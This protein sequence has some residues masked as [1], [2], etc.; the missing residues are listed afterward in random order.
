YG[1][2]VL[3]PAKYNNPNGYY[4]VWE[5]CCRNGIIKNIVDPDVEGM[6]FYMEFP[7]VVKNNMRFYNSS[8]QFKKITGDFP[9]KNQPFTF[10][11]SG[12]DFNNDSLVYRIATPLAGH[13]F[14]GGSAMPNPGPY[15]SIDWAPG[16]SRTNQIPGVPPFNINSQTGIINFTPV[17]EGLYVFSVEVDEYRNGEKIGMVKRDFQV[18][19]INCPPNEPPDVS[20]K[21]PDQTDY[22]ST[23]DTLLLSL[24]KD[25]CFTLSIIDSNTYEL[26]DDD[27]IVVK[28]SSDD[29]PPSIVS[30]TSTLLVTPS[31]PIAN[32]SICF[33]ACN[34]LFITEDTT[35]NILVT[36]TDA[37]KCPMSLA[38]FDTL[39]IK[40]RYK[41]QVNVPPTLGVIP[42]SLTYN[43]TVGKPL[44]FDLYAE[45]IDPN[46]VISINGSGIGFEMSDKGM[47]FNNVA[48]LDSIGSKFMWTPNCEDIQE[49]K[50]KLRFIAKDNSCQKQNQDTLFIEIIVADTV[51]GIANISPPNLFTPNGDGLNE[52]FEIPDMPQG[53]CEFFFRKI[54]IFNRWGSKVFESTDPNFKWSGDKNPRGVYF[55]TIDINKKEFKGWVELVR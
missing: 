33:D 23:T 48:G 26:N 2:V 45:D 55:Y 5:N 51:T 43:A 25:T 17:L 6:A 7:P 27:I 39:D 32:T 21:Y 40:I 49:E 16:Y 11:F 29:L 24:E 54:T 28:I 14:A 1:D 31:D 4:I 52:Y 34:K 46:D 3:D 30:F 15:D 35:F 22:N 44:S 36:I 47:S 12:T 41:P 13:A 53:N 8:P 9:C 20:L 18:L 42:S 19:I 50:Y 37:P 10:D 38:F